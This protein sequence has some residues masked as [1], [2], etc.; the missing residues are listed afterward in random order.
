MDCLL[1]RAKTSRYTAER[2]SA[3]DELHGMEQVISFPEQFRAQISEELQA[4]EGTTLE[5]FE[6]MIR[7][8]NDGE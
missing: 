3:L 7:S 8:K 1:N 4:R 5:T 2:L 6:N